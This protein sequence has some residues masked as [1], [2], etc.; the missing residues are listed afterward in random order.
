MPYIINGQLV[1]AIGGELS[2]GICTQDE[3]NTRLVVH[4]ISF[5]NNSARKT[6]VHIIKIDIVMIL[7]WQLPLALE[8]I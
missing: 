3:A 6:S 4:L 7:N 1:I 2:I 8:W 5:L